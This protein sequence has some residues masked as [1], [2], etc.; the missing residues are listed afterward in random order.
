MAAVHKPFDYHL[1]KDPENILNKF[2]LDVPGSTTLDTEQSTTTMGTLI[3][4]CFSD[5]PSDCTKYQKLFFDSDVVDI[6]DHEILTMELLKEVGIAQAGHIINL[7]SY[8]G[9]E[10]FGVVKR[11]S[12]CEHSRIQDR[13]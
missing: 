7:V 2:V 3:G 11:H 1:A 8:K 10:R 12:K 5:K 6:P 4:E 9:K 13:R